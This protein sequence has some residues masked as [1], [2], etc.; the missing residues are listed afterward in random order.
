MQLL[1]SSQEV[2]ADGPPCFKLD[3]LA[4]VCL[5]EGTV[6]VGWCIVVVLHVPVRVLH[7]LIPSRS[8]FMIL[9][10]LGLIVSDDVVRV[11]SEGTVA[12]G[13]LVVHVHLPLGPV[14]L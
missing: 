1:Q 2:E 12:A 9:M 10:R 4:W 13:G 6:A 7:V 11:S 8:T 14:I 3:G 5:T